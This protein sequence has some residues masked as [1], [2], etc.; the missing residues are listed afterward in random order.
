MVKDVTVTTT[1]EDG[2]ILLSLNVDLSIGNLQLPHATLPII[3]PKD[4]REVGQVSLTGTSNGENLLSI[5][6]NLSDAKNLDLVSVRLPNRAMVPLIGDNQVLKIPIKNVVIYL[7]LA[8][9]A[10]M[11]GVAIPIKSFDSLGKKVGT[12]VLMPVFSKRGTLGA[13]GLYTSKI[14]GE[15][16]VAVIAD[17]SQKLQGLTELTHSAIAQQQQ[18]DTSFESNSVSRSQ[19]RRID[20]ELYRLHR[21]RQKLEM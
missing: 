4:G 15:N 11:I 5:D 12:S 2:D 1:V 20:R 21:K 18:I 16:G 14:R 13:A 7:S 19:K 17:I 3:L 9:Q 8:E 6:I 10:Q